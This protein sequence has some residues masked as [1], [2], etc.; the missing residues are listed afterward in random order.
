MLSRGLIKGHVVFKHQDLFHNY[1]YVFYA[2]QIAVLYN[3]F[4]AEINGTNQC[5]WYYMLLF[6]AFQM[7]LA[8][9]YAI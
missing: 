4:V 1:L 7:I 9:Q 5:A 8:S 6:S 2:L 3:L